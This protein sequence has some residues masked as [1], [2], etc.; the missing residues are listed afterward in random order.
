MNQKLNKAVRDIEKV[1]ALMY[2]IETSYL[3]IEFIPEEKEKVDRGVNAFYAL[4]DAIKKVSED[5]NALIEDESL[6]DV[7]YAVNDVRRKN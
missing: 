6:I 7:I 2:A 4:W 1:D 3:N 5:L